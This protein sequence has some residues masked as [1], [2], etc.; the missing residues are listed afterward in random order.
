MSQV[1]HKHSTFSLSR[2][3]HVCPLLSLSSYRPSF[4][5]WRTY[6]EGQ[7][8]EKILGAVG[9]PPFRFRTKLSKGAAGKGGR[10]GA[11]AEVNLPEHVRGALANDQGA[12]AGRVAK[13][14][15]TFGSV[16]PVAARRRTG[17]ERKETGEATGEL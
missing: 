1:P 7:D 3:R 13:M 10:H 12:K 17:Q 11:A 16:E 9:E 5:P 6:L 14:M 15:Q 2:L 4:P 8:A